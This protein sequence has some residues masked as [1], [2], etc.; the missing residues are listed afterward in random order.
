MEAV[1]ISSDFIIDL[2]LQFYYRGG[3]PVADEVI[4]ARPLCRAEG[5]TVEC[6]MDCL[7]DCGFSALVSSMNSP[8][9]SALIL[10]AYDNRKTVH[11]S[12]HERD[13]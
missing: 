8:W 12:S 6:V 13:I 10:F 9:E 7:H 2:E 11:D 1:E 5:E 4:L 3:G